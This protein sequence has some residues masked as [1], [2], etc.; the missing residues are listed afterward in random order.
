MLELAAGPKCTRPPAAGP[1]SKV[2]CAPTPCSPKG[3][4]NT[5][6]VAAPTSH[7]PSVVLGAAIGLSCSMVCVVVA[8]AGEAGQAS[9]MW[10]SGTASRHRRSACGRLV[11]ACRSTACARHALLL[12]LLPARAAGHLDEVVVHRLDQRLQRLG[13][14]RLRCTWD[15]CRAHGGTAQSTARAHPTDSRWCVG[16]CAEGAAPQHAAAQGAV[17]CGPPWPL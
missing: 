4:V 16:L 5:R 11:P 1:L 8:E 13:L 10:A 9:G 2:P 6:T 17:R 12:L 3:T 14:P 7:T 15:A